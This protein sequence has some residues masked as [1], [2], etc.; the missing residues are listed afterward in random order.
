LE[1][2]REKECL[3]EVGVGVG[4]GG[5]VVLEDWL[6]Y[7][8]RKVRNLVWPAAASSGVVDGLYLSG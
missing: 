1:V 6:A 4:V 7:R 3:L 5:D 8:R 2:R